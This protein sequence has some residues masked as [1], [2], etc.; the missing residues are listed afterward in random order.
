MAVRVLGLF[1]PSVAQFDA[2]Q[3]QLP[4]EAQ[5]GPMSDLIIFRCPHTGM[6]V[7]TDL[8]GHFKLGGVLR[9]R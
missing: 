3:G 7:Q 2:D 4:T 5:I 8:S 9:C 1:R 6:N